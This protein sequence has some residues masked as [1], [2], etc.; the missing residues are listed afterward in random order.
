[1]S[2][3]DKKDAK[4]VAPKWGTWDWIKAYPWS[5]M[6]KDRKRR[7]RKALGLELPDFATVE[8][9]VNTTI[10]LLRRFG[11]LLNKKTYDKVMKNTLFVDDFLKASKN[12][13]IAAALA[14]KWSLA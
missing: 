12:S 13:I 6:D 7:V 14:R 5:D 10:D 2:K 9:D 3:T 11:I 4:M 1:M 8:D